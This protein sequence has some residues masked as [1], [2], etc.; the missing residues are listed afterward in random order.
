MTIGTR[1]K[2]GLQHLEER[3]VRSGSDEAVGIVRDVT[4]RKRGRQL[5]ALAAEQ[6]ALSRVA[7]AVATERRREAVF[8]V[9][10]EEVAPVRRNVGGDQYETDTDEVT[11]V[12]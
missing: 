12:G 2:Q 3:I 11:V 8:N 4:E 10:T 6:A 5:E 1:S 7:V 9:V